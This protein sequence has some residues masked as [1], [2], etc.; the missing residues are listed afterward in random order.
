MST[1]RRVLGIFDVNPFQWFQSG[2][3]D[4]D[5][6]GVMNEDSVDDAGEQ[7]VYVV[8]IPR[9]MVYVMALVV[10]VFVV[11]IV[12]CA[13]NKTSISDRRRKEKI[14]VDRP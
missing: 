5:T 1:G 2:H 12:C 8:S 11:M 10:V 9:N 6:L 3:P 14:I 7:P 13:M 4:E